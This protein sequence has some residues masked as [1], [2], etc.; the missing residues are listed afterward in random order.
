MI[1]TVLSIAKVA[2]NQAKSGN[3][4][5]PISGKF[6]TPIDTKHSLFHDRFIEVKSFMGT[7]TFYWSKN[8][9]ETSRIKGRSYFLYLINRGEM[10]KSD[11]IPIVIQNPIEEILNNPIWEKEVENYY[12]SKL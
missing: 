2:L 7:P 3:N 5:T 6:W 4:W 8:E 12:I 1:L 11:Y 10:N 9:I